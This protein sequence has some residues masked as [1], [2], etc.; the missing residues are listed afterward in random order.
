MTAKAKVVV[1]CAACQLDGGWHYDDPDQPTRP[2]H[3]AARAAENALRIVELAHEEQTKQAREIVR[4][5]ADSMLEFSA[6]NIRKQMLDAGIEGP[7]VGAAFKWA[8]THGLIEATGRSVQSTEA[9]TRHRINVWRSIA[10][11]KALGVA[12]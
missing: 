5:A 11:A 7:V 1:L 6:N 3:D 12:S 2:H 8:E 10:R 9:S 4:Y